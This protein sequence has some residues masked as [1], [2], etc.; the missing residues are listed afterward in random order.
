M[1]YINNDRRDKLI[2]PKIKRKV[3]IARIDKNFSVPGIGDFNIVYANVKKTP[4]VIEGLPWFKQNKSAY[5]RIP[6]TLTA[7]KTNEGIIALSN[8]TAGV[9]VRFRSDSPVVTVR[10]KL[11][12]SSDMNHMPRAGSAGFDSYCTPND[13]KQQ[14]N[15]TVQP[16]RDQIDIEALLGLNPGEGMCDWLINFPLYGGVESVEIGIVSGS[17]LEPPTPHKIE[18]PVLFYGSSITQGGCASRP[19]NAYTPMLC[20]AVDAPQI[21]LGF[22]GSARGEAALAE[23]IGKLK[24]SAFIYDYDHNAPSPEHL[25]KTHEKFF[26]IVRKLQPELPIIMLSKC[27]YKN[28][29][30]CNLRREI[31]RTTYRNAVEHGDRNVYFIDGETLFGRKMPDACTVD[32]CHP[33]DLGF[34]RMYKHILPLLKK[35]LKK[36]PR[37]GV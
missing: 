37:K 22:S 32:G 26:R 8:H 1:R 4:F 17:A 3:D 10:A 5:Y 19:G 28:I 30:D 14:Y 27:D 2:M 13:G 31:I 16:N 9:A 18:N 23:E 11:A 21:N 20:R 25:K 29:P 24:L 15:K 36:Y 12:Y 7:E 33:N 34:Y 35:I 6:K